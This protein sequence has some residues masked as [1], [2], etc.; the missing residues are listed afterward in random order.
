MDLYIALK[1]TEPK[2][3]KFM[4]NLP[5]LWNVAFAINQQ[6][7]RKTEPDTPRVT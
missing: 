1:S 3:D 4:K 2:T 6:R 5:K 7:T